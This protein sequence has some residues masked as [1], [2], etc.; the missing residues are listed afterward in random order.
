MYP[1]EAWLAEA[2]SHLEKTGRPLV[3]L[4]YAQSLD[5]SLSDRPGRSYA[6]SGAQTLQLTHRLRSLHAA[7]LVGI[8]TVL[9][10]DPRL[11]V[12]LADGKQPRPIVLDSS[13][14]TP[15]SARLIQSAVL[16]PWIITTRHAQ[17]E[18]RTVLESTGAE[19]IELPDDERGRIA[20]P[21]LLEYLGQRGIS[22][23]MVEG[24]GRILQAFLDAQLA[25]LAI[26][27][28]APLF[29]GGVP[30]IEPWGR[31]IQTP[32]RL[33]EAGSQQLG[34]DVVIWGRLKAPSPIHSN[35]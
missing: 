31:S 30:V 4:C 35:Y 16:P 6:I 19:I 14:Q 24:G 11:T 12:R 33:S 27:T 1:F 3:S 21:A 29:L 8:G 5:G 34:E 32:L 25:D 15:A 7:I 2:N 10:D 13:L 22:R 9:A 17:P 28:I 23:L 26:I 20:L 18:R